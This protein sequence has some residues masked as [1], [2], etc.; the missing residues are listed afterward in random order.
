MKN[1]RKYF[2]VTS[3]EEKWGLYLTTTGYNKIEP[4]DAKTYPATREHPS[5]HAFTW[6]TGRTLKEYQLVYITSGTGVFESANVPQQPVYGGTCFLLYPGMWHRYKP[7]ENS[8]WTEYWIGFKGYYPDNFM[9]QDFF[10]NSGPVIEL[11]ADEEILILFHK[12]FATVEEGQLGYPQ[13]LSSILLEIMARIHSHSYYGQQHNDQEQS[14]VLKA[15]FLMREAIEESTNI[16]DIVKE[17]PVSYSKFRKMFKQVTGESPNQYYLNLRL[18]KAKHLL[19]STHLPVNE[20]AY[21]TGFE[22]VFYFSRLFKK[23]H[24]VSPKAY[25]EQEKS[26]GVKEAR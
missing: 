15:K 22:S 7:H 5:S 4:E 2:T 17:L 9:K 8:G 18:K 13:V 21:Q 10:R 1:F 12:L 16:E 11:G 20:V 19:D 26:K 24:G 14:L 6:K 25:R 3:L 23:K